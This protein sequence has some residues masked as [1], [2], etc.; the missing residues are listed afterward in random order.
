MRPRPSL[1]Q[2]LV[3]ATL[4]ASLW[5]GRG[6]ARGDF[7]EDFASPNPAWRL[8]AS[9]GAQLL[10]RR[11]LS[12]GVDKSLRF[13]QIRLVAGTGYS[14]PLAYE[15]EAIP[16]IDETGCEC[17]IRCNQPGVQLGLRIEFP[18]SKNKANGRQLSTVVY[19][20]RYTEV[21]R[22]QTLTV[23]Q[24]PLLAER[25]ARMMRT[26]PGQQVDTR[27]AFISHVVLLAPGG[28]GA[29]VVDVCQLRLA[30]VGPAAMPSVLVGTT[31]PQLNAAQAT[32]IS[33]PKPP[34]EIR[35]EAQTL[36]AERKPFLPKLL[37][38]HGES[39]ELVRDLGFNGLWL[40]APPTE[41]L[42]VSADSMSLWIVAPPP[43]DM[44][45]VR[46]DSAWRTVLCWQCGDGL[47]LSD[48]D[49]TNS[50]SD[51][52]RH[53]DQNLRR[54]LAASVA[55]FSGAF[56]RYIDIIAVP[57]HTNRPGTS[58][59]DAGRTIASARRE[60]GP[61]CVVVA[62]IA[63]DRPAGLASQLAAF[64]IAGKGWIE[65]AI[66]RDH[67]IESIASG[68]RG[69]V[70]RST[71]SIAGDGLEARRLRLHLAEV[72]GQV[73]KGEAWLARGGAMT[74]L[75]DNQQRLTAH[76]WQLDRTRLCLPVARQEWPRGDGVTTEPAT[77]IAP[78]VPITSAGY[79]FALNDLLP[80]GLERQAG[81]AALKVD[82][83]WQQDLL[84]LTDDVRAAQAIRNDV[85]RGAPAALRLRRDRL[86]AD[87]ETLGELHRA[88]PKHRQ[89]VATGDLLP[90]AK[91]L[92]TQ[93]DLAA[94]AS[95]L[96]RATGMCD[97]LALRIDQAFAVMKR[98][99][100]ATPENES[101]PTATIPAAWPMH[102]EL[103]DI[104]RQL[105]RGE[106]VLP[107]GNFE[108]I[109]ELQRL[110]W[111]HTQRASGNHESIVSL[112]ADS[113]HTGAAA[114]RLAT[115]PRATKTDEGPSVWIES[116]TI[117]IAK[118]DLVEITGW[119]RVAPNRGA[120]ATLEIFDS[121][122]TAD[123][124]VDVAG[125]GTWQP[126]RLVRKAAEAEQLSLTFAL[127]GSG[128]ADIDAVM[129]QTIV[130]RPAAVAAQRTPPR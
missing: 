70:M 93:I 76:M 12:E 91:D 71:Q 105:P 4:L 128:V 65:P 48:L 39:L 20:S 21:G 37:E 63:L 52:I 109:A 120:A 115:R 66:V 33:K 74:S 42:V 2:V 59:I 64:S 86:R 47:M 29:T 27:E 130:P 121:L 54:P 117:P 7:S 62:E 16:I 125:N 8:E 23:A 107:G 67:V 44:T 34:V 51:T 92:L 116:P 61:G 58:P 89:S 123:L 98:Q 88:M 13:E 95:D 3:V 104:M 122:G 57:C 111:R 6:V 72:N 68:A 9:S 28:P 90:L 11:R 15:V 102:A 83:R 73:T 35:I 60:L 101:V 40:D 113:P 36:Q 112:T 19:G 82:P 46:A 85:R 10:G 126:F 100:V 80:V 84:L 99:V 32:T 24:I 49:I 110:G 78:G 79:R 106:N 17:R 18:R 127:A 45:L 96:S 77:F 81:G 97:E 94:T 75:T 129:I 69:Y 30:G 5:L 50:I 119:A 124:A 14:A 26:V 25:N 22:W 56:D 53:R 118:G 87:F 1:R 38:Y 43:E 31:G 108:Q 41:A 55:Q 114:L 103:V